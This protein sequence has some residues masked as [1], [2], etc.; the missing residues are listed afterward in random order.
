MSRSPADSST[1]SGA[2]FY[3]E[4]HLPTNAVLSMGAQYNRTVTDAPTGLDTQTN[5]YDA[6]LK[7]PISGAPLTAILKGHFE[8]TSTGGA[9]PTSL[10]SLEQIAGV[11]AAAKHHHPGRPSAS[12]STRNIQASTTSSTRR[13]SPI[14]SRR[15]STT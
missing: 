13:F 5:V 2:T 3:A 15:S 7:Q 9:A 10:P 4:G 8:G 6:Q 12:S 14:G 1:T 11:E